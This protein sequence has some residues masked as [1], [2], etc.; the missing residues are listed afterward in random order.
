MILPREKR[1]GKFPDPCGCKGHG[2]YD[3]MDVKMSE[4]RRFHAIRR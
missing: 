3:M 4:R 2:V 1:G